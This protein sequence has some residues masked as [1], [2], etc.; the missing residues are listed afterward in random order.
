VE[1]IYQLDAIVLYLGVD[2]ELFTPGT[3]PSSDFLISVGSLTPLKGFDFII[4][5]LAQI[6][7]EARPP[8]TIVCNFAIPNERAH[9]MNLSDSLGVELRIMQGI[10]DSQLVA[11]Y[12]DACLTVYAPIREPFGLVALESMSCG[13]PVVAVAEG[14]VA[15]TVRHEE[16]GMLVGRDEQAFA[17]AILNLV[18]HPQLSQRM[19]QAGRRDI[20][21]N[22][23][24]NRSAERLVTILSACARSD[25]GAEFSEFNLQDDKGYTVAAKP[26]Q[27]ERA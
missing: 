16:T 22:W 14:G 25:G 9:L 15:E 3:E 20:E 4:R 21:A 1:A 7:P 24:W 18:K 8:L 2:A 12:R 19:G 5:S 17:S 13:T 10:G 26:H 23:T 27:I 11:F 6:P